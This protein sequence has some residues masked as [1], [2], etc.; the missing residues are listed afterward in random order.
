[1]ENKKPKQFLK[2][3]AK[4]PEGSPYKYITVLSVDYWGIDEKFGKP[5]FSINNWKLQEN[6]EALGY[7]SVD[8]MIAE[9]K[10][11]VNTGKDYEDIIGSGVD[12][13]ELPF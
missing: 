3:V 10:L 5:K 4:A 11:Y 13:N 8:D 12:A 2:L 6:L 1:M 9:K 7:N